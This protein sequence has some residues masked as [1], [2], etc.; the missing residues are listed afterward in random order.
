M[1]SPEDKIRVFI[2][3]TRGDQAFV[4]KLVDYLE[5]VGFQPSWDR[6]LKAGEGFSPQL[7]DF[8]SQSH[9]FIPFVTENSNQRGWVQQEIGYALALNI[10]I[11]PIAIGT[12][13]VGIISSMEAVRLDRDLPPS[14]AP[15]GRDQMTAALSHENLARR[16]P[17][18]RFQDLVTKAASHDEATPCHFVW[19]NESRIRLLGNY[20]EMVKA[21]GHFGMVRQ[22]T[23]LTSFCTMD[24]HPHH[25]YWLLRYGG[26]HGR[27][28]HHLEMICK[29][30]NELLEHVRQK[31]CRLI[32]H[33]DQD[34]SQYGPASKLARLAGLID[35]LENPPHAEVHVA[36]NVSPATGDSL[37]LVGDWFSATSVPIR[38]GPGHRQTVFS[39]HAP[40]A[41]KLA[42]SFDKEFE[43]LLQA[44]HLQERDS[45]DYAIAQ[46]REWK[47]KEAQ[48][49]GFDFPDDKLDRALVLAVFARFA[50]QANKSS[51][52]RRK[53]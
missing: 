43:S 15:V 34:Y 41:R 4:L 10:P 13:P 16:L 22:K 23:G 35:F 8:I 19:D 14:L 27:E 7:R 25:L 50:R 42:K 26:E 49:L 53:T 38:V 20:A 36:L 9:V 17:T 37:T 30:R 44:H 11:L 40:S 18:S 45:R 28:H 48:S 31:G 32:I 6:E 21:Y 2:S 24:L 33:T 39:M 3:Y 1:P 51:K 47:A 52:P 29:E 46:L 5:Q 12:D